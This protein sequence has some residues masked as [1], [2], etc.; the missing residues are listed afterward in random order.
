M[1]LFRDVSTLIHNNNLLPTKDPTKHYTTSIY[2]TPL[3]DI[4]TQQILLQQPTKETI[5]S[6]I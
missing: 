1:R 6:K 4:K 3:Q 5:P 2:N